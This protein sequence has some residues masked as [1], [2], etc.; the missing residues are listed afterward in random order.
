MKRFLNLIEEIL[1][2]FYSRIIRHTSLPVIEI[3]FYRIFL[4]LFF[5]L[6]RQ[7]YSWLGEVP[8]GF[9]K[10]NI[11]TPAKLFEGL[12]PAIYF[13]IVDISIIVLLL[14]VILGIKARIAF[15]LLFLITI[16]NNAFM[17]SFGKIDHS[18]FS[19]LIFLLF[20]FT[21][22]GTKFALVPDKKIKI[23]NI[24]IAIFALCLVF[25]FFTAGY[26]KAL[27]WLDLDLSTSGV[28]SWFYGGFFNLDRKDL[29]AEYFFLVP[30]WVTEIMDYT[31]VIFEISGIFFLYYS[32]RSWHLYLILASFFHLTNTLILNISFLNHFAVYGLWLLSPLLL[33]YKFAVLVLGL[34]FFVKGLYLA[35]VLWLILLTISAYSWQKDYYRKIQ[36]SGEAGL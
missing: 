13:E 7:S 27:N 34:A 6:F 16:I 2:G 24:A 10:P 21:N 33:R 4:G 25:A 14:L 1:Y 12:P 19:A 32:R 22:S 26:E 8:P 28:L 31:A 35:V 17:Y 23:Q 3:S 9:Y 20:F 18:I 29:L 15:L 11:L 30:A 36:N 5:L